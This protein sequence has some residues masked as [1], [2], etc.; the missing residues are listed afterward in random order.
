M[1]SFKYL[2]LILI[3]LIFTSCASNKGNSGKIKKD[4]SIEEIK[5]D[6]LT[7]VTNTFK[8]GPNI[9]YNNATKPRREMSSSSSK[10]SFPN[11]PISIKFQNS[12]LREALIGLG[13]LANRNV[14]VDPN[15]QGILN[16]SVVNEPWN[17]VINT[18]IE[19]NGLVQ[20][21]DND[22]EIIKISAGGTSARFK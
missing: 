3:A 14:V 12:D 15:V 20:S 21:S 11:F 2:S 8:E 16:F 6:G 10:I 19:M 1:T 5:R 17:N 4:I 22:S 9:G 7:T 13:N 18:V